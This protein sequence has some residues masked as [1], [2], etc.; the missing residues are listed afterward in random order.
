MCENDEI[1]NSLNKIRLKAGVTQEELARA[2]GVSRQT[3]ISIE[4]ENCTPSVF[5]AM[6]ISRFFGKRVEE[7]FSLVN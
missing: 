1:V 6:K 7:V 3:I 2:I 5:L 4:K